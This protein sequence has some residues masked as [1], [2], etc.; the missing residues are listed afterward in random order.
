MKLYKRH[1]DVFS[2]RYKYVNLVY[3]FLIPVPCTG[4]MSSIIRCFLSCG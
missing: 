3:L 1:A 2:D 4:Q